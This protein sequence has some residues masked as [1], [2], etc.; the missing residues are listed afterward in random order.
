MPSSD[1]G[2][3]SSVLSPL[4]GCCWRAGNGRLEDEDNDAVIAPRLDKPSLRDAWV[5]EFSGTYSYVLSAKSAPRRAAWLAVAAAAFSLGA[6]AV[7]VPPL[8]PAQAADSPSVWLAD[9]YSIDP[10]QPG[11]GTAAAAAAAAASAAAEPANATSA[12][13]ITKAASCIVAHSNSLALSAVSWVLA[14]LAVLQ[15]AH[16]LRAEYILSSVKRNPSLTPSA[17]S[18]LGLPA[19]EDVMDVDAVV[20]AAERVAPS[21][22]C[23]R[24]FAWR[25]GVFRQAADAAAIAAAAAKSASSSS[26]SGSTAWGASSPGASPSQARFGIARRGGMSRIAGADADADADVGRGF[27]QSD[28]PSTPAGGR[29]S[30]WRLTPSKRFGRD[31]SDVDGSTSSGHFIESVTSITSPGF[32]GMG[33]EA[34]AVAASPEARS[35]GLAGS[36]GLALTALA[37]RL[38]AQGLDPAARGAGGLY[39]SDGGDDDVAGFAGASLGSGTHAQHRGFA[40]GGAGGSATMGGFAAAFKSAR[41]GGSGE[42]GTDGPVGRSATHFDRGT[43]LSFGDDRGGYGFGSDVGGGGMG[44]SSWSSSSSSAAASAAAAAMAGSGP[45]YAPAPAADSWAAR[46][47]GGGVSSAGSAGPGVGSAGKSSVHTTDLGLLVV[48]WA[49]LSTMRGAAGGLNGA[50]LQA[51]R[52]ETAASLGMEVKNNTLLP[53]RINAAGIADRCSQSGRLP[54]ISEAF[55]RRRRER[56]VSLAVADEDAIGAGGAAGGMASRWM[57]SDDVIRALEQGVGSAGDMSLRR[58]LGSRGRGGR[59]RAYGSE[60]TVDEAIRYV[61]LEA[62]EAIQAVFRAAVPVRPSEAEATSL[63]IKDAKH[64]ADSSAGGAAGS[65]GAGGGGGAGL[66]GSLMDD[67]LAGDGGAM[68]GYGSKATFGTSSHVG[69]IPGRAGIQRVTMNLWAEK[70]AIESWLPVPPAAAT[71]TAGLRVALERLQALEM[72][73]ADAASS[74]GMSLRQALPGVSDDWIVFGWFQ[75]YMDAFVRVYRRNRSEEEG[76]GETR[77]TARPALTDR[78]DDAADPFSE[79]LTSGDSSGGSAGRAARAAAAAAAAAAVSLGTA[80][81]ASG[82]GGSGGYTSSSSVQG[83]GSGGGAMRLSAD[84]DHADESGSA[85]GGSASASASATPWSDMYVRT[86][87]PVSEAEAEELSLAGHP[88]IVLLG[89]SPAHGTAPDNFQASVVFAGL[90]SPAEPRRPASGMRASRSGSSKG[91]IGSAVGGGERAVQVVC[92]DVLG[93]IGLFCW[94]IH[95]RHGGRLP[96]WEVP[97]PAAFGASLFGAGSSVRAWG[98]AAEDEAAAEEAAA[99]RAVAQAEADDSDAEDEQA[100]AAMG[101][102]RASSSPRR[103]IRRF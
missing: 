65:G 50:Q 95:D 60:M 92:S 40:F 69:R 54:T 29:A 17:R 35:L 51:L 74:A 13:S 71:R 96:P 85:A 1:E 101:R 90:R 81:G 77:P 89:G 100:A 83:G 86:R 73:G 27:D 55:L 25:D 7:H 31:Q 53:F 49:A 2:M 70:A 16:R 32:A 63:A 98:R 75:S 9:C 15:L 3:A 44:A 97:M 46:S 72:A 58:G 6:I 66:A 34:A 64:S 93:A 28:G 30:T 56:D 24:P 102:Q 33:V 41:D 91:H 12:F 19:E 88:H 8:S 26:S 5:R 82:S 62:D 99:R 14:L 18:A 80:G 21:S 48:P 45:R 23:R 52:R 79:A 59:G 76:S 20:R 94:L 10:Q 42:T 36:P 84:A 39:G 61:L 68:D 103:R 57:A 87:A 78:L 67:G 4:R 47:A 43:Y 11:H 37:R 38:H 22:C